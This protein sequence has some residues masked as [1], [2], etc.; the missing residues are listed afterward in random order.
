M[1]SRGSWNAESV[2]FENQSSIP[3]IAVVGGRNVLAFDATA[4]ELCVLK[5]VAPVGLTGTLSLIVHGFMASAVADTV[6]LRAAVEALTPGDATDEDAGESYDSENY[7]T[8]AAVPAT[9]GYPFSTTI[10]L[11][12]KDSIAVGDKYRIRFGRDADGTGSTDSA[13]GDL[14]VDAIE[15]QDGA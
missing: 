9:A 1:A 3:E 5:G 12:N 15:L 6:G 14:Y 8:S 7:A 13:T 11:T 2:T 4:D 10:T